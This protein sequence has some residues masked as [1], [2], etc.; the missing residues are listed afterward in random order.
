[1]KN[2]VLASLALSAAV[3]AAPDPLDVA[4]RAVSYFLQ[5]SPFSDLWS[6]QYGPAIEFSAIF[7]L[8]HAFG[9]NWTAQISNQLDFF[10]N[11]QSYPGYKVLNNIT[12]PF[13]SAVGDYIG[14]MPIAYLSRWHYSGEPS[15]SRDWALATRIAD[16]YIM[17]WPYRLPDGTFSRHAGWPGQPDQ[18]ASFLWSDDEFMGLTPLARLARA[19]APNAAAYVDLIAPMKLTYAQ[20]MQYNAPPAAN[21]PADGL[22]FH[23]FNNAGPTTSCCFWGRANGWVMMSHIEVLEA[24]A[25]VDPTHPAFPGVIA[26]LRKQAAALARLQNNDPSDGRWHQVLNDTSTF[27]ETSVTS[28]SLYSIATGVMNGWLDKAT[29]DPVIQAAWQGLAAQVLP[30][31]T[32][33]GICSG[34]GIEPNA[35]AYNTRPTTYAA[36]SP[37]LG[38]VFRAILAYARY[39]GI[40]Q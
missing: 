39:M 26:L 10:L 38:S 28:M 4:T 19:G 33:S 31:G 12:M 6:W 25:E 7:E 3:M 20:H 1:M 23:G 40:V 14:L 18:N 17:Q 16:Q 37:G 15:G 9:T 22:F 11:N 32:V 24:L 30:N 27:L 21:D 8:S 36:S 29:F 35:A 13:D 2:R 5:Q 34:T